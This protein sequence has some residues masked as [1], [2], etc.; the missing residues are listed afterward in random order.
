MK[1]NRFCFLVCLFIINN[2]L[3]S[4]SIKT[5]PAQYDSLFIAAML[6]AQNPT[7]DKIYDGLTIIEG[8]PDLI[9][10]LIDGERHILVVSWKSHESWYTDPG[11]KDST[12]I[13]PLWV[14]VAPQVKL[15]CEEYF[16]TLPDPVMRLNQLLGLQPTSEEVFFLEAWV[17]PGDLWRPCPDNETDDSECGLNLPDD[18]TPEYRQWFN[19]TRATQYV[20]CSD[21]MFVY[22]G[23]NEGYP[24]TQ[25]GYT[26]DWNPSN[27]TNIG[28]SEFVLPANKYFYVRGKYLTDEY[29]ALGRSHK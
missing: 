9:D 8:N 24:W 19:N 5:D 10:T 14:T 4:Q 23:I 6:D 17:K 12:G 15:K 13:Y 1:M 18:V 29:C 21:T 22:S 27:E 2:L 28:L 20:D 25:L 11:Q 26:Y 7:P 16:E 3:L